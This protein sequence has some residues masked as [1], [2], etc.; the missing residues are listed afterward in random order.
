[1]LNVPSD[2]TSAFK[3]EIA[4]F[5][6]LFDRKCDACLA[7][8]ILYNFSFHLS[9]ILHAISAF[10]QCAQK[11]P[12]LFVQV[13]NEIGFHSPARIFVSVCLFFFSCSR[14]RKRKRTKKRSAVRGFRALRSATKGI[15]FGNYQTFLKKSLDQK[16]LEQK[17]RFALIKT[18]KYFALAKNVH[19]SSECTL[20]YSMVSVITPPWPPNICHVPLPSSAASASRSAFA[21]AG[22][23]STPVIK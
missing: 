1:M 16:T 21:I 22:S 4:V 18:K 17:K 13:H 9:R 2:H 12:L 19:P 8:S 14:R 11:P 7:V 23:V 3:F 6:S 5:K 20:F 10:R 15:A